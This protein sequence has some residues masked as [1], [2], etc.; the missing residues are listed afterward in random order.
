MS[1]CVL[2]F[3]TLQ[4]DIQEPAPVGGEGAPVDAFIEIP[5]ERR[6]GTLGVVEVK[7]I[8]RIDGMNLHF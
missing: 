1:F 2:G 7:W 4:L 8:A 6:A 5:V 3:E